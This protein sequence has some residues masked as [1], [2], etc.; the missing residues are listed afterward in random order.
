MDDETTFQPFLLKGYLRYPEGHAPREYYPSL[1]PKI[2]PVSLHWAADTAWGWIYRAKQDELFDPAR[3][4]VKPSQRNPNTI[5]G[6]FSDLLLDERRPFTALPLM[7]VKV[8]F[9]VDILVDYDNL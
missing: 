9:P 1:G 4:M 6:F 8:T 2:N 7:N 5:Q 3:V